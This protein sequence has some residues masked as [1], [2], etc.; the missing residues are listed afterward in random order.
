LRLNQQLKTNK[1]LK[2]KIMATNNTAIP[3]AANQLATI[4]RL[5]EAK[6]YPAMYQYIADLIKQ[7][8]F[9]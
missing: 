8:L 7:V 3:F 2:D 6:A 5:G 9:Q 1:L 4:T